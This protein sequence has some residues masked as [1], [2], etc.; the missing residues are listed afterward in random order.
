MVRCLEWLGFGMVLVSEALFLK[1]LIVQQATCL[2]L[3]GLRARGLRSLTM[4]G[5]DLSLDPSKPLGRGLGRRGTKSAGEGK[6]QRRSLGGLS[7]RVVFSWFAECRDLVFDCMG[8][9]AH[10]GVSGLRCF[11]A[12]PAFDRLGSNATKAEPNTT[13]TPSGTFDG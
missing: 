12:A 1:R 2:S 7:G 4:K 11:C 8:S 10:G 9:H 5:S 3:E 13:I 6:K